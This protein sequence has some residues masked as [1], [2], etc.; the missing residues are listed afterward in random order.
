MTAKPLQLPCVRDPGFSFLCACCARPPSY[1][2]HHPCAR[3][4]DSAATNTEFHNVDNNNNYGN[5]AHDRFSLHLSSQVLMVGG[6]CDTFTYLFSSLE[7]WVHRFLALPN[8]HLSCLDKYGTRVDSTYL[9][10]CQ[11]TY[12]PTYLG[13]YLLHQNKKRMLLGT[14]IHTTP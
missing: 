8:P 3:L 7:K 9:G 1:I 13:T 6:C 14:P 4:N 11:G 10:T 5:E 12:L 2:L